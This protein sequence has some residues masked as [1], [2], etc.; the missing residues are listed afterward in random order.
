MCP[1]LVLKPIAA[2]QVRVRVEAAEKCVRQGDLPDVVLDFDPVFDH[3]RA[4]DLHRFP[5]GRLIDDALGVGL[6][7]ARRGDAFAIGAG[8]HGDDITRLGEHGG[9]LDAAQWGGLGAGM[10]VVAIEGDMQVGGN[11]RG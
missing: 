6:A 9:S 11:Q 2:Y 1:A 8:M 5:G 4:L 3:L 7:A 10:G